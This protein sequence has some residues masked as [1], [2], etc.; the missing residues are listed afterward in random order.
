MGAL[1]SELAPPTG[2]VYTA[3][4][5]VGGWGEPSKFESEVSGMT[6]QTRDGPQSLAEDGPAP[7]L[8]LDLASL[9]SVLE[10]IPTMRVTLIVSSDAKPIEIVIRPLGEDMPS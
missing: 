10:H 1:A 5:A 6:R 3:H 8:W 4:D 7:G 2:L 9:P